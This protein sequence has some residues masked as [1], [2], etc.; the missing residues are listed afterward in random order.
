M[1][2][3]E[4]KTRMALSFS[5]KLSALLHGITSKH[6]GDFYCLSCLCSFRTENKLRSNEKKYISVEL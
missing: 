5:K 3:N 6:E 4:V 1:V 2:P